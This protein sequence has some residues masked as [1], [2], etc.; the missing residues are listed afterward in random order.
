MKLTEQQRNHMVRAIV[1]SINDAQVSDEYSFG[2]ELDI[3]WSA[4]NE[5]YRMIPAKG[6]KSWESPRDISLWIEDLSDAALLE[7]YCEAEYIDLEEFAEHIEKELET[8][9]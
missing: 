4:K 3:V 9:E 8:E 5:A 1:H 2:E 6:K 7:G